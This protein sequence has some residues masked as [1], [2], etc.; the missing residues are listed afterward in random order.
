MKVLFE[1]LYALF[2]TD[3][4]FKTAMGS[5]FYLH[6]ADQENASYP[7]AVYSK[8]AGSPDWTFTEDQEDITIQIS[9]F[10]EK[11]SATEALE[12]FE[13]CKSLFDDAALSV[14]G[15]STILMQRGPDRLIRDPESNVWQV[16]VDYEILLEKARA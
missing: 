8:P 11:N 4:T 5:Q 16:V 10:S 6:E 9:I 7:Y 15:Y 1:A 13:Y 2:S 12:A 3:N 14:S